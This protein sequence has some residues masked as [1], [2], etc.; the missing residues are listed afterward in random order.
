MTYVQPELLVHTG[1]GPLSFAVERAD[2]K[3]K[4]AAGGTRILGDVNNDGRV[5]ISDALIVATYGLDSSI[6]IPNY[7]DISLG[8][9]NKDGRINISDALMIAT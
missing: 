6:T 9:V 4:P 1:M 7:G 3:P 8:D 5:N 2:S